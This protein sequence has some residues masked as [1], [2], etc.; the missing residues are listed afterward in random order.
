MAKLQA[1]SKRKATGGKYHHLKGKRL[2]QLGHTMLEIT[3]GDKKTKK[4]RGLGGKSKDRALILKEANV[5]DPKTNKHQKSEI[6]SVKENPANIH[7][8]RRNTITKGAIVETKLGPA[9]VTS[10]PGQ[11]GA[12]NAVLVEKSDIPKAPESKVVKPEAIPEAPAPETKAEIEP[13]PAPSK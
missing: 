3:I 13:A 6:T 1:Y 7:F 5:L 12:I 8:V 11:T 10:R 2:A 4:M 9:R